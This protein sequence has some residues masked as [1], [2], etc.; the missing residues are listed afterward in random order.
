MEW[1]P[2]LQGDEIPAKNQGELEV[3]FWSQ[4]M[5]G[6]EAACLSLSSASGRKTRM[7]G[8]VP[9]QAKPGPCPEATCKDS[10]E[11]VGVTNPAS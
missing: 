10:K 1:R 8:M 4:N 9:C 5:Q 7:L 11:Y 6:T 2:L 3:I